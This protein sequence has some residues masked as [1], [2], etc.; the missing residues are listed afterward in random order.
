MHSMRTLEKTT[1]WSGGG[2]GLLPSRYFSLIGDKALRGFFDRGILSVLDPIFGGEIM[3]DDLQKVA[4]TLIDLNTLLGEEQGRRLVLELLEEP[5]RTE[6]EERV[7]NL[8][9][10]SD[11]WSAGEVKQARDFFG[12]IEDSIVPPPPLA[13]EEL[14]PSFGLFEY[15]RR[16]VDKIM[17][18]LIDD[19]KRAVLHFPTGA[20]KTRTAM[21]VVTHFLSTN[22]PSVVVWLASTKELLEQAVDSF[23][24]GWTHLGNRTIQI[25]SMWGE[26]SPNLAKFTDGFL[27]VGLAKGWA[28]ARRVDPDW[29]V[30][31]SQRVRLVVFDEAHQS[32]A[33]TYQQI[34]EELTLNYQCSLLGLT[35]TPGRTWADIDEDGRVAD[36]YAH[37]KVSLEVPD[38]DPI[39]YLIEMGY[40]AKPRFS[41]MLS[42]SGVALNDH[43]LASIANELEIPNY[44]VESLTMNKQYV[45]AVIKAVQ[46]LVATGHKRILV[47]AATVDH[48]RT[49]VA[50]LLVKTIQALLVLGSTDKRTRERNIRTFKSDDDKPMV[51][52]NYGVLTTGFDAPKASAAI[53]ARPTKSLV[54]YSQMVGRATRGPKAGGTETCEIVTVIDPALPGFSDIAEAFNNWEDVWR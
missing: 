24:N 53:I 31:M 8:I 25:G 12:L 38:G 15:Q 3:G 10:N 41:I 26:F 29:A 7:G 33:K 2:P 49:L 18:L 28:T 23:R 30:R 4:Q 1:P 6:L 36:F 43:D 11:S 42:E 45:M 35:A 48:A 17:P 37:N 40:L 13:I 44:I 50:M 19:E 9:K 54:L 52:V 32:I 47:F 21:H 16:A 34:T 27:A 14:E 39:R 22:E 20:G 46:E 51:L 5:K